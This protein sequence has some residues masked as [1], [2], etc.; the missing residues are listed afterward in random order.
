MIY[1]VTCNP[2]LD[3]VLRLPGPLAEGST[4]RAAETLIQPGGKG[5]NVSAVLRA[6]DT[7]SIALGFAAGESGAWLERLLAD[8]G[9]HTDFVR[10]PAG[11]T[12]INVKLK[13]GRE[14]EI[15]APGPDIP[16]QAVE[17]LCR[18]LD[19]LQAG[20]SLILAGSVPKCLPAD[21]YA[22]LLQRLAVRGVRAVVDAEGQ[23]LADVLPWHPFLVKP[24]RAELEGLL[25]CALT[26]DALVA[27]GAAALQARGAQQVLVSLG[28]DGALLR[29][30]DGRTLRLAAPAG[31]VRNSVGAGDSMVAGFLAG[32]A[33]SGGDPAAALRLAV[34]AGSA[35]AFADG[36]A[37]GPA[38]RRLAESLPQPREICRNDD[39]NK[40]C[41]QTAD[42]KTEKSL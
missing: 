39:G 33:A 22:R 26:N 34:A 6:L 29:T 25:G 32:W 23:L 15:N 20:D 40:A 24:N 38:I 13:A 27:E 36:L 2:A 18:R 17:A 3:Y 28:G 16:P 30:A 5:V 1:T 21:F 7:D 41:F 19:G 31:T 14:T 11:Q 42:R 8:S 10:L 35:T 9:L 12:R 37:E 4:N